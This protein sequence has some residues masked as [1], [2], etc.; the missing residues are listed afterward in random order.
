MSPL[1]RLT[2]LQ[3]LICVI[4]AL[5]FAFD[6]YEVLMAPLVVGPAIAE[7]TGARPGTPD[8]N[9]W[10]GMFFWIP[11]IVGGAFGLLG[12]YLTDRFGRRRVLVW[13]ILLY[14]FSALGA[15]FST[16]IE[17]L[18]VL[19]ST[20]YIGV[21]VEFVAA[22]AWIAELFDDPKQRESA[23]GYTQAFS[24]VGGLLVTAMYAIA[25]TYRGNL[26]PIK[27]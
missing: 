5:G 17:M 10:V 19:R 15:G 16:S 21:F 6:I 14:A 11:A 1:P 24:S 4:A 20:T 9:F 13:S 7:L 25:V 27:R 22:V 2:G 3:W 23:L 12:G 18:L 26:P 8:F